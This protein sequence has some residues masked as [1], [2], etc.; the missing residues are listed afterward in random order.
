MIA[1]GKTTLYYFRKT[2]GE[3][4]VVTRAQENTRVE[5]D[6]RQNREES[7]DLSPVYREA[8]VDTESTGHDRKIWNK[9]PV[10]QSKLAL[11]RCCSCAGVI[12][13]PH[14][15]K[16]LPPSIEMAARA[17]PPPL[18]SHLELG[19]HSLALHLPYIP[20]WHRSAA[21]SAMLFRETRADSVCRRTPPPTSPHPGAPRYGRLASGASTGL[22]DR[23]SNQE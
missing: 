8:S 23:T 21:A 9:S 13:T 14:M 15:H 1:R 20:A 12:F 18:D 7:S 17:D 2:R 16:R 3:E 11:E 22:G 6:R 10:V 4:S 19:R 5:V